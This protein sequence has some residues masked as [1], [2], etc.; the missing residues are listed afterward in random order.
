MRRQQTHQAPRTHARTSAEVYC[1]RDNR[2]YPTCPYVQEGESCP[3]LHEV[4]TADALFEPTSMEPGPET[5][6][7]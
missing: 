2:V 5:T 4:E 1:R 3:C 6:R 7:G